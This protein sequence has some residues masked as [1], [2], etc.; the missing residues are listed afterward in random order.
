MNKLKSRKT[1]F[2]VQH[3]ISNGVKTMITIEVAS[4]SKYV[5]LTEHD[6]NYWLDQNKTLIYKALLND[7]V[8]LSRIQ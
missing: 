8:S 4:T 2:T 1:Q 6:F 7:G 5:N 3:K